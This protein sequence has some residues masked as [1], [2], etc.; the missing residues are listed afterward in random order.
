ML[1]EADV[2][3]AARSMMEQYGSNAQYRAKQRAQRLLHD[4]ARESA[5][6]WLQIAT[7]IDK[8]SVAS[9]HESCR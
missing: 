6:I 4:N 9:R 8:L 3:R 1:D 5:R 2:A 7:A